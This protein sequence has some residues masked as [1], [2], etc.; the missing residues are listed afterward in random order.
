MSSAFVHA[1]TQHMEKILEV[2][3]SVAHLL[4]SILG[5]KSRAFI[6]QSCRNIDVGSDME[7][8]RDF[9]SLLKVSL[10]WWQVCMLV[11]GSL[12]LVMSLCLQLY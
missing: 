3:R 2:G 7:L 9:E 11:L 6:T 1:R 10:W 8:S 5:R 4:M 12:V